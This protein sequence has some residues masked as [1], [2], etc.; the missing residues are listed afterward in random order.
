MYRFKI[1]P[2]KIPMMFSLR[3]TKTLSKIYMESQGTP[4]CQ[5]YLEKRLKWEDLF[6]L[7]SKLSRK[8][9]QLK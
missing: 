5:N 9:Q 2:T 7:I 6:F 3:N 1:I 8:L 4:N